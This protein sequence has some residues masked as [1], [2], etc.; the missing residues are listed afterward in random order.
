M[1]PRLHEAQP[2]GRI[3]DEIVSRQVQVGRDRWTWNDRSE[4]AKLPRLRPL[5]RRSLASL[6]ASGFWLPADV[7]NATIVPFMGC[8]LGCPYCFQNPGLAPKG[9]SRA[10]R[11]PAIAM[12]SETVHATA[13][14]V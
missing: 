4:L 10:P 14:F 1:R 12:S 9:S 8:N 7:F 5:R 13:A 3:S 11:L 2:S 6:Q